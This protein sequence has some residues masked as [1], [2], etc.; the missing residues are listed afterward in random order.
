VAQET[1]VKAIIYTPDLRTV[2]ALFSNVVLRS[3]V[4]SITGSP[5]NVL[6]EAMQEQGRQQQA[7]ILVPT[8]AKRF[9]IL[10]V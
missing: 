4:S 9:I 1:T 3:M 5:E 10:I 6:F 2:S 7:S 8:A